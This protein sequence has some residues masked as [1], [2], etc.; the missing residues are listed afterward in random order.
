MLFQLLPSARPE[1]A[2]DLCYELKR[3]QLIHKSCTERQ[4]KTDIPVIDG[5]FPFQLFLSKED[6]DG[7]QLVGETSQSPLLSGNRKGRFQQRS[8]YITV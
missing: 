2:L 8:Y 4:K 6:K 3:I 7:P 1:I 5:T